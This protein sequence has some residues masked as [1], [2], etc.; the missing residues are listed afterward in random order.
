MLVDT[1]PTS[2]GST[3]PPT[4]PAANSG[5]TAA[6]RLGATSR[7]TPAQS[8]GK[9]AATPRPA[10]ADGADDAADRSRRAAENQDRGDGGDQTRHEEPGLADPAQHQG[11][12]QPTRRLRVQN[13]VGA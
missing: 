5:P 4:P 12:E 6:G 9:I 13:A 2:Q 8:N 1:T 7:V 3:A 11:S 10:S